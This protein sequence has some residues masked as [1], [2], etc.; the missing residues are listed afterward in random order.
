MEEQDRRNDAN[1]AVISEREAAIAQLS[2][3]LQRLQEQQEELTQQMVEQ[4][5]AAAATQGEM[6]RTIAQHEKT[7]AKKKE[8]LKTC[9]SSISSH[10]PSPSMTF[11]DLPRRRTSRRA[12]AG[13]RPVPRSRPISLLL[14]LPA[15]C[16]LTQG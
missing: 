3:Q 12:S 2:K 10:L 4:Q 7:I 15:T 6:G 1:L 14:S 13:L 16:L 5:A 8:D 11:H 9:V